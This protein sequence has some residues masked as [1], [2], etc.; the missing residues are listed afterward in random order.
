MSVDLSKSH[1]AM[2]THQHEVAYASFVKLLVVGSTLCIL[3]LIGMAAFL[4]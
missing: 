3:I 2:D 1:R 4:T